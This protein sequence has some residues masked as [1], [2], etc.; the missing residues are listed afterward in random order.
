MDAEFDYI[1]P[2]PVDEN[3]AC[4]DCVWSEE[5]SRYGGMD[6]CHRLKTGINILGTC[7]GFEQWDYK[8]PRPWEW[9]TSPQIP[10]G[11]PNSDSENPE[12]PSGEQT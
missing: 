6:W 3:A 8:S 7:R 4:G 10:T 11:L 5:D 2:V 9:A 1:G 12:S